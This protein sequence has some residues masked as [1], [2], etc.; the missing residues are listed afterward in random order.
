MSSQELSF[1]N[2]QPVTSPVYPQM[3]DA[4]NP[5]A[6]GYVGH[7]GQWSRAAL[8]SSSPGM[9]PVAPQG[10]GDFR[11]MTANPYGQPQERGPGFGHGQG[12]YEPCIENGEAFCAYNNMEMGVQGGGA[13]GDFW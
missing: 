2:G 12:S 13:K 7:G 6:T 4:T 3:G 8:F 1:W 11:P 9:H 10:M 5:N